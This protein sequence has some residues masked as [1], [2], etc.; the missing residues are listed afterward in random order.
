MARVG[1]G[2]E[3]FLYQRTWPESGWVESFFCTNPKV[4]VGWIGNP[5]QP[6]NFHNPT[7]PSIFG[8]G[9]GCSKLRR[10]EKW[11]N[12]L[13]S[14]EVRR[15]TQ[16][17]EVWWKWNRKLSGEIVDDDF[18]WETQRRGRVEKWELRREFDGGIKRWLASNVDVRYE[19][20]TTSMEKTNAV[21][22]ER[23]RWRA[24]GQWDRWSSLQLL[25]QSRVSKRRERKFAPW[26]VH[27]RHVVGLDNMIHGRA[28]WAWGFFF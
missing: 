16:S 26:R 25:I 22:W 11:R 12:N 4:R 23:W 15:E 20:R 21:R 27:V 1:L 14:G 5:T 3:F 8:L 7:Q 13:P 9:S 24:E 6:V 19:I 18:W 10:D 28:A 17:G 2:W